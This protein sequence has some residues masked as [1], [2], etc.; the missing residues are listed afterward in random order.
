MPFRS[1][2]PVC[3][4]AYVFN[5]LNRKMSI[6]FTLFPLQEENVTTFFITQ[7]LGET[8]LNGRT[9]DWLATVWTIYICRS[10]DQHRRQFPYIR[11]NLMLSF[12][13]YSQF[14]I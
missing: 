8:G 10:C 1:N 14:S 9:D 6:I 5:F 7:S 2:V 3:S 13:L 4:D 11:E 12:A